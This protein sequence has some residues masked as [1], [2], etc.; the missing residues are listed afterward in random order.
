VDR[1]VH[2]LRSGEE[3]R[4]WVLNEYKFDIEDDAKSRI[5]EG[6]D[7]E[8]LDDFERRARQLVTDGYREKGWLVDYSEEEKGKI[9][10]MMEEDKEFW[11][12]EDEE[13]QEEFKK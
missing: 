13:I 11:K 10:Q 5:D 8:R 12:E 4:K 3:H 2:L 7:E 9:E 1:Y 6:F